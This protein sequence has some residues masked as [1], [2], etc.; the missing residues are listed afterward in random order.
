[1]IRE[2]IAYNPTA[3]FRSL[4]HLRH[5]VF[6]DSAQQDGRNGRFS[7]LA[8][9]PLLHLYSENQEVHLCFRNRTF[10]LKT[11]PWE[12]IDAQLSRFRV[13]DAAVHS[14]PLGAAIGYFGYEAA[15]WIEPRLA[16]PEKPATLQ[17]PDVWFAF[18]DVLLVFD[19]HDHRAWLVSTG[20]D[21][22]GDQSLKQAGFRRDQFLDEIQSGIIPFPRPLVASPD[23]MR[24]LMNLEEY[25]QRFQVIQNY[26]RK[27]DT[28]QVNLTYPF[29]GELAG[30]PQ[31]IYLRLRELNP[32]SFA[33][34][35]DL[36]DSQILSSSPERFL[37]MNLR[38]ISTIPIKGTCGKT[39]P[40]QADLH[41]AQELYHSQKDRAEL[42]MI[43]DLLRNDLGK[44][45]EYGSVSV[46]EI[47]SLSEHETVFHLSSRIQGSLKSSYLHLDALRACFP[48]G[49]ITGAPKIRSMEIIQELEPWKRGPYTGSLG[50]IGFNGV[51]DFNILIRTLLHQNGKTSFHVGGGI[52]ADSEIDLEYEETRHKA[53]GILRLW[54]PESGTPA[55]HRT[56]RS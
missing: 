49:S 47:C 41:R 32:A 54:R 25:A 9:D 13:R 21:E 15:K 16:F 3:A 34:Y 14:F 46:P 28:Y 27:G 17:F 29:A 43:T 52:T 31:E 4:A 11:D 55:T 5:C 51:S 56:M 33:A 30:A 23:G 45:C 36:G 37:E 53:R 18:Y 26:I 40:R 1:M 24:P 12:L 48:G 50:Y 20:F 6:L 2:E 38:R 42:L 8:G 7:I 10:S 19:H 44:I 35:L 22:N 39:G